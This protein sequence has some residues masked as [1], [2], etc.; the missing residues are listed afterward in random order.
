MASQPSLRK[1]RPQPSP[2][3]SWSAELFGLSA[4]KP[5]LKRH[6]TIS[7]R[8]A[9]LFLFAARL[10]SVFF[11]I[12][13]DCDEVFNYWEP[14]HYLLYGYGLQTWEYS[15]RY[16]LRPYLYLLLH[17]TV[18]A[19]AAL[20]FGSESG[21]VAV[22]HITKAS[23]AFFS[24]VS[25]ALLYRAVHRHL[26]PNIAKMFLLLLC[27]S[28]GMFT[29]ATSL[30]PS[31]FTM[32]TLTAAS[33]AVLNSDHRRVVLYAMVGVIW[34]WAVAGVAFLPYAV[35]LLLVGNPMVYLPAGM[36]F[37]TG[38][39]VPMIGC[40]RLFYGKWTFSLWNF[41]R[42]NVFGGGDS[43]L[44]GV[45]GPSFYM[46][47]GLNN[48]NFILP[49]GLI[50]P[51]VALL[52]LLQVTGNEWRPRVLIAL[53]PIYVWLAAITALPHKEERFMY[54][55]YPLL[56]LAAAA[57]LASFRTLT[58]TILGKLFSRRFA[59]WL[60]RG[61]TAVVVIA[62]VL[63]SVSRSIALVVNYGAPMRLYT[64]LPQIPEEANTTNSEVV[65]V[66]VGDEWYRY[67]SSFFLPG[68]AYRLQF[69][70]SGFD[71]MLPIAFNA[72]QGGTAASPPQLNDRNEGHP[73]TYWNST[74]DCHFLFLLQQADDPEP[75]SV[76]WEVIAKEPFVEASNSPPLWRALYIPVLSA[77]HVHWTQYVLLSSKTLLDRQKNI[78][79]EDAESA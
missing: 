35:L 57:T 78:N 10:L 58:S 21:K 47:N 22:F 62:I 63:L 41:I 28:S 68:S 72:S 38:T 16:A 29:S 54:V 77:Q 19:P 67:P 73:D 74:A 69:V 33:A 13:H 12:I 36:V 4:S 79:T 7:T 52:D 60:S 55:I 48:L 43:A 50:Y 15:A 46:R 39:I 9:F 27:V 66:C 75:D 53:S 8:V 24:A 61:A 5:K 32:Y 6:R 2:D 3:K 23:L 40:D 20:W 30:L 56:C 71:G 64:Q 44:Y 17:T 26:S 18:A 49:L 14:L 51:L 11:N 1:R 42:Y 25:E 37:L 34:G 76:H 45:E 31:S 70:K 59:R 65:S